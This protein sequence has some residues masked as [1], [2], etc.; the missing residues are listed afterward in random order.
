[1]LYQKVNLTKICPHH[2]NT[3]TFNPDSTQIKNHIADLNSSWKMNLYFLKNLP[4]AFWW[5]VKV[6]SCSP[7]RSEVEVPFN[8]RTQNP[9]KSIYFAA[10]AGTAELSTGLMATIALRGRG[11]I[12]MLITNF[13]IQFLKKASQTLTFTC[14][15]GIKIIEAVQKA[16]ETGE[17]VKVV[18]SSIGTL[19]D[20]IV[21]SKSKNYLVF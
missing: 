1:M 7:Y 4:S 14:E 9:F 13:E 6:K 10:Q 15:E 21:A 16:I 18:V 12:S 2:S 5:G 19:P 17:G 3:N 11:K 20:G 8:W